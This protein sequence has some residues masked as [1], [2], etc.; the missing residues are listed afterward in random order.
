MSYT[1]SLPPFIFIHTSFP[2]C[3]RVQLNK[4]CMNK[5][6]GGQKEEEEEEREEKECEEEEQRKWR[7]GERYQIED[8]EENK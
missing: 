6:K 3:V 1:P 5:G 8:E 7:V 2:L 4:L